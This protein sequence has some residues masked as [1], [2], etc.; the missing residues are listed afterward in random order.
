MNPAQP[1]KAPPG[2]AFAA[3]GIDPEAVGKI[4]AIVGEYLEA[5]GSMDPADPEFDRTVASLGRLGERDFVATA[6]MSGR[7]LDRRFNAMSGLLAAKAPMARRLAELRKAAAEFDPARLRLGQSRSRHDELDQLSHY[8]D[9][10][11]RSR[12]RIEGI[13][14]ALNEG[15]LELEQDSATIGREQL[16]LAHEMETLRQYAFMAARL[17]EELSARI[18]AVAAADPA[19][20]Q[21]LRLD[22]LTVV[23]RRRQEILTQLAIATQG[24]AALEI[25][26]QNNDEVVR[27]IAAATTSTAAA[28]RTAVMVAQ[29]A[30]SQRVTLEQLDA[31]NQATATMAGQAGEFRARLPDA[32]A[33]VAILQQAWGDVYAALDRVDANKAEALRTISSADRELTRGEGRSRV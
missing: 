16:S 8:F 22:V 30:A 14:L 5:I 17:D 25:V 27:A 33:P 18:V 24:Y 2:S 32:G 28:L 31:A 3:E 23:R 20:A 1:E 6:A 11:A 13:L 9:R 12:D 26:E 29:A 19:R 15:R 7:L 21:T 4:E 10:F